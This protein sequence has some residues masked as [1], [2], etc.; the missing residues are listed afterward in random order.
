MRLGH[1]TTLAC[2]M[3][4]LQMTWAYEISRLLPPFVFCPRLPHEPSLPAAGNAMVVTMHVPAPCPWEL[5][6]VCALPCTQAVRTCAHTVG[7]QRHTAGACEPACVDWHVYRS[8]RL[9]LRLTRPTLSQNII[10]RKRL[11]CVPAC[12]R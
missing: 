2:G 3:H 1:P 11:T 10:V 7:W 5:H 12:M 9:K 8:N 6:T 4:A